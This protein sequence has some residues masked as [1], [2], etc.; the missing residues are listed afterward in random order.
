MIFLA[1]LSEPFVFSQI[2]FV[3]R[4]IRAFVGITV[5]LLL[6]LEKNKFRFSEILV[7]LILGII[8]L[9]EATLQRSP[10]NNVISSY[11]I[12]LIAFS[13]FI[14]LKEDNLKF[15]LL[16][17]LWLIFS[18]ALSFGAITSFFVH[19]FSS[20]D[21]DFLNL[22]SMDLFN[23]KYIYRES[24]FGFTIN[25]DF[26]F[27]NLVRVCSFFKE[28]QFA[29][30]FFAINMLIGLNNIK[31]I[32]RKFFFANLLAGLLTFSYTFYLVFGV[33]LFLSIKNKIIKIVLFIIFLG[34]FFMLY[35]FN[36]FRFIFDNFLNS[37][38]FSDRLQRMVNG[39]NVLLN[40][41]ISNLFFGHGINTFQEVNKDDLGRSI[42]SGLLFLIY[43]LGFL[44]SCFILILIKFF[45]NKDRRLIS[46]CLVYLLVLPWCKFYISW[47]LIILCGLSYDKNVFK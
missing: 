29:G 13:L 9:F 32:Y 27:I 45:A 47:Y 34:L 44:I 26:G 40:A 5:L 41:S 2:D 31:L 10:L 16:L 42:S 39:I 11:V 33:V 21:A 12:I 15:N 36:N 37:S 22:N 18:F 25:K 14:I 46:I 17:K 30:M 7:Y 19:Q 43:E 1:L 28:P 3:G 6:F 20:L 24:I 8:I 35:Q 4:E 23:P 38:S